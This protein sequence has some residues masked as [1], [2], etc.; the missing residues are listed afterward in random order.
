MEG[1]KRVLEHILGE[2]GTFKELLHSDPLFSADQMN[3]TLCEIAAQQKIDSILL[4]ITTFTHESLLMIIRLLR[5]RY[6]NTDIAC[7]YSNAQ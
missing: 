4:D 6:P 1:N 7:V 2:K 3:S 5:L